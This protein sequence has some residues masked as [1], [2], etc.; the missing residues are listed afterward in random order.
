MKITAPQGRP[1]S[2]PE[3]DLLIPQVVERLEDALIELKV[4]GEQEALLKWRFEEYQARARVLVRPM[5]AGE[6]SAKED[7]DSA[8]LEYVF[9]AD[10]FARGAPDPNF[11]GQTLID[12]GMARDLA[13][14]AYDNQRAELRALQAELD[15][16]RTLHVSGREHAP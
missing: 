10:D 6:K 14:N 15:T 5:F 8:A 3:I 12:V 13:S 9:E 11:V 7:R 16:L 2:L 1:W 4:L